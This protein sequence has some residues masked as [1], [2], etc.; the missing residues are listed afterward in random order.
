MR[1][2]LCL[3]KRYIYHETCRFLPQPIV[4]DLSPKYVIVLN[5]W[6]ENFIVHSGSNY[7]IQT[8][9]SIMKNTYDLEGKK[10]IM[11]II[12]IISFFIYK[13]INLKRI[14]WTYERFYDIWDYF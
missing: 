5:I 6:R 14:A 9:L 3:F 8:K 12:W 10:D 2:L 4:L 13:I 7:L 1:I 11:L